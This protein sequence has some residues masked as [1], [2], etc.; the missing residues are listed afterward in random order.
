MEFKLGAWISHSKTLSITPTEL[1]CYFLRNSIEKIKWFFVIFSHFSKTI[2]TWPPQKVNK[3]IVLRLS[4]LKY[5]DACVSYIQL[6]KK[7]PEIK[8]LDKKI[9]RI[10]KKKKERNEDQNANIINT[11]RYSADILSRQTKKY[12]TTSTINEG[13]TEYLKD[14]WF[15]GYIWLKY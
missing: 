8:N 10:N 2:L 14:L 6:A 1:S 9:Y 3:S 11:L 13:Q 15:A 12:F 4:L 5:K 7:R